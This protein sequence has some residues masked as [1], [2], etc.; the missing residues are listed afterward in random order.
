MQCFPPLITDLEIN[1]AKESGSISNA[2]TC[3]EARRRM[4]TGT[5]WTVARNL[6]VVSSPVEL[7]DETAMKEMRSLSSTHQAV[8][9]TM[10]QDRIPKTRRIKKRIFFAMAVWMPCEEERTEALC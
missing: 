4:C 7:S 5:A 2:L 3:Q 6:V 1:S 8:G 9:H 10:R